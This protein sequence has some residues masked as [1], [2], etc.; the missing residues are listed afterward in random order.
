MCN[1]VLI[2]DTQRGLKTKVRSCREL[3]NA[4][5]LLVVCGCDNV[6]V[7]PIGCCNALF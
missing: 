4:D 2:L 6:V 1:F 5:G 7:V 3:D